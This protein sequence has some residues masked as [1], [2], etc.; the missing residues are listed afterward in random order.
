LVYGNAIL[1]A[2][3]VKSVTVVKRSLAA[4]FSGII[5][6]LFEAPNVMMYYEDA[7]SGVEKID[8]ELKELQ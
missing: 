6:P 1:D 3:K 5:N 2:D 8:K 4:G 7:G